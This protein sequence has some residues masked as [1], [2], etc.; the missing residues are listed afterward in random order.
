MRVQVLWFRL[1][2]QYYRAEPE[3]QNRLCQ[4]HTHDTHLRLLLGKPL[5]DML[6]I[7]QCDYRIQTV[8]IL[9]GII[10]EERLNHRCWVSQTSRLND[11]TIKFLDLLVQLLKCFDEVSS[12]RAADAA[13]TE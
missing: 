7:N 13:Y 12:Y 4:I 8:H 9:D 6:C 5:Q 10:D 3:Q 11:D 2:Y 1:Q